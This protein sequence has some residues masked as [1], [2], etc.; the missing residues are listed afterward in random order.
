MWI[1]GTLSTAPAAPHSAWSSRIQPD[2]GGL[3]DATRALL[4]EAWL[5]A[6]A[7]EHASVAAFSR[8]SLE[9]MR[10]GA[11]PELLADVHDAARDE[12]RH[13]QA[14]Y[15]LASAYAGT[16]L[17][18]GALPLPDRLPLASSVEALAR[19]VA[20]EGCRDETLAALLAAEAAASATDPAVRQVLDEVARDEARH[21]ALSWRI[22]QWCLAEAPEVTSEIDAILNAEPRRVSVPEPDTA[23][24]R[25]HGVLGERATW[26][27]HVRGT[28]DVVQATWSALQSDGSRVA[29]A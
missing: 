9:L 16:D 11:P 7:A 12:I 24:L 8:L 15:T 13:A 5:R 10:L 26:Q 22:L 20:A 19:D 6:A 21:A 25:D 28:R 4:T 29:I 3:D 2:V 1:E 18:P 27:C 23:V 14:A 17:G